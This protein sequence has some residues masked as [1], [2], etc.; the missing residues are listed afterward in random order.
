VWGSIGWQENVCKRKR[1][2]I[3]K[4]GNRERRNYERKYDKKKQ[5]K[6]Q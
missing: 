5:R 2:R 1:K 6:R 4:I 3:C